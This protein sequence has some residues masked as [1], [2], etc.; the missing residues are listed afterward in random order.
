MQYNN[1]VEICTLVAVFFYVLQVLRQL[2]PVPVM[3][4]KEQPH[5]TWQRLGFRKG[6]TIS[7]SR[8]PSNYFLSL[9]FIIQK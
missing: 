8:K 1:M 4:N 2:Q 5:S 9:Y 7:G 3:E 6:Y